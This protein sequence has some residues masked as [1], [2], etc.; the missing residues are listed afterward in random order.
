MATRKPASQ[1]SRRVGRQGML[2]AMGVIREV[3]L[4]EAPPGDGDLC[5]P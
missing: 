2:E 1:R 4:E 3:F 5:F